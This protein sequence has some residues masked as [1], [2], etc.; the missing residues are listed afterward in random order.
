MNK[1]ENLNF[2]PDALRPAC[3]RASIT[4]GDYTLSVVYG[5]NGLYGN[6]PTHDTYEVAVTQ[7]GHE[8]LLPLQY[9]SEVLGWQNSEEI[10]SLM[11]ILQTE[12]GFGDCLRILKRTKY[13]RRFNNI[14]HM[15]DEAF[16]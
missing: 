12:P 11:K 2:K 13:S 8:D 7:D 5:Q 6:G 15:R 10:S 1:F 16:S 9:D 14:S 4:L 3:F